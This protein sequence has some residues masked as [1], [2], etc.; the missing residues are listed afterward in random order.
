MLSFSLVCPLAHTLLILSASCCALAKDTRGYLLYETGSITAF[1]SNVQQIQNTQ[2]LKA[3]QLVLE[4]QGIQFPPLH[5]PPSWLD[6]ATQKLNILPEKTSL[7]TPQCEGLFGSVRDDGHGSG[8]RTFAPNS[9]RLKRLRHHLCNL[10]KS[11]TYMFIDV[12]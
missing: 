11:F 3:F 1:T 8:A 4:K 2:L 7:K 12:Y 5:W 10:N 9:K 6:E